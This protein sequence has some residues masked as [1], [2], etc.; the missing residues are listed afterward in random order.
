MI[1]I[2]FYNETIKRLQRIVEQNQTE[3]DLKF[4]IFGDVYKL[5]SL[6]EGKEGQVIQGGQEFVL[7]ITVPPA[8]LPE[9]AVKVPRVDIEAR[10][11][12]A[13]ANEFNME[14]EE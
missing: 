12:Q 4:D 9:G 6:E 14:E 7:R 13:R 2:D 11:A 5:R 1:N 10:M 3:A 8:D